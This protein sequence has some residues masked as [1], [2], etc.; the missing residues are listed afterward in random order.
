MGK[1]SKIGFRK[2][3]LKMSKFL[4]DLSWDEV[5]KLDRANTIVLVP[6]GSTEQHGYHMPLGTDFIIAETVVRR[7][8][9]AIGD[10][11]PL[12]AAPTIPIGQSPEHMEYCGTISLKPATLLALVEDI[13]GSLAHHGFKKVV[14]IN[15]HGGNTDILNAFSYD[16]RYR[17]N[18][19][20]YI[21]DT[22][23][24]ILGDFEKPVK[25]ESRKDTDFHA[26][27]IETSALMAITPELVKMDK[28]QPA[29]PVRYANADKMKFPGP[30]KMGWS[31]LDVSDSGVS[32]EPQYASIEKGKV[33]LDYVVEQ[34]VLGIKEVYK[35]DGPACK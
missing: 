23:S 13:A 9:E 5:K 19:Y 8:I 10:D 20:M 18:A 7:V 35:W 1:E 26:G 14:F 16:F 34:A 30:V 27:E 32:G 25:Q 15:G 4:R 24:Y 28:A 29:I 17:Y 11:I 21:I 33:L 22:C 2:D 12:L 6:I 3:N 31:S